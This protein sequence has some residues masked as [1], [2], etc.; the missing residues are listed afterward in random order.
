MM[1][2]EHKQFIKEFITETMSKETQKALIE[3]CCESIRAFKSCISRN[4]I[5]MREPRLKTLIDVIAIENSLTHHNLLW[6][7]QSDGGMVRIAHQCAEFM[8]LDLIEEFDTDLS[9]E[10]NIELWKLKKI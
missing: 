5:C 9:L 8:I 4:E 2:K 7:Q 10:E 3:M 6:Q 1:D